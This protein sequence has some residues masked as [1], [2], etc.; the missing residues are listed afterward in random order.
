MVQYQQVL[1]YSDAGSSLSLRASLS[2]RMVY[3]VA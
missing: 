3:E 1:T 2:A